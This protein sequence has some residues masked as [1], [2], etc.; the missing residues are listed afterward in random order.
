[1]AHD[2]M[3]NIWLWALAALVVF[4]AQRLL[5]NKSGRQATRAAAPV[6]GEWV[7]V[8]NSDQQVLMVGRKLAAVTRLGDGA[9]AVWGAIAVDQV[10]PALI[11]DIKSLTTPVYLDPNHIFARIVVAADEGETVIIGDLADTAMIEKLKRAIAEHSATVDLRLQ[12]ASQSIG[13]IKEP[14]AQAKFDALWGEY[15]H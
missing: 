8:L 6:L 9:F 13:L 11:E 12:V 5:F 7:E 3:N 1:M 10:Q 4:I 14:D 15:V 2:D